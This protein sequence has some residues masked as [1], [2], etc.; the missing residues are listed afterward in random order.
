MSMKVSSEATKRFSIMR[1]YGC[2]RSERRISRA[3]LRVCHGAIGTCDQNI[4]MP[5]PA[6]RSGPTCGWAGRACKLFEQLALALEARMGDYEAAGDLARR[7]PDHLV[8]QAADALGGV[9]PQFVEQADG[10]I[11]AGGPA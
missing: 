6:C 10:R 2:G 8:P 7:R 3:T 11:G 9:T 1:R 5:S 4:S